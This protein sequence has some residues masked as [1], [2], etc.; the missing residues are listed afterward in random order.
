MRMRMREEDKH[1]SLPCLLPLHA[2]S[3]GRGGRREGWRAGDA[4]RTA[5]G[6]YI[7]APLLTTW[8]RIRRKAEWQWGTSMR[9]TV[10]G[11][12]APIIPLVD[13]HSYGACR[14]SIATPRSTT[15][16]SRNRSRALA[17]RRASGCVYHRAIIPASSA[18]YTAHSL[19][20]PMALGTAFY[21]S[22][23]PHTPRGTSARLVPLIP[24]HAQP[25]SLLAACWLFSCANH[26]NHAI[27]MR[28]RSGTPRP[29]LPGARTE[30]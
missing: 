18:A 29:P 12:R 26:L 13:C 9:S 28:A 16:I 21:P 4:R 15:P 19:R 27:R 6:K 30:E 5:A 24:A 22:L 17:H 3:H 2:C 25:Y 20:I 7:P 8:G 1:P 23:D 11:P 14:G 10:D